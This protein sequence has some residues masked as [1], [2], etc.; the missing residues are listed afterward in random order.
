MDYFNVGFIQPS[1]SSQIESYYCGCTMT[2]PIEDYESHQDVCALR[3]VECHHCNK[4]IKF[5]NIQNHF[6]FL[7]LKIIRKCHHNECDFSGN[8]VMMFEHLKECL[9][10]ITS[11]AIDMN[12]YDWLDCD[13]DTIKVFGRTL[14]NK[15][16][17][18]NI[19]NYSKQASFNKDYS[20]KLI[21]IWLKFN[22][23]EENN[24]ETTCDFNY[25]V[26][27]SDIIL[28]HKK[29]SAP[30]YICYFELECIS[31]HDGY[32]QSYIKTDDIIMI[33]MAF[34]NKKKILI[35]LGDCDPID[36]TE[37]IIASTNKDLF[38]KFQ[39]IIVRE[40]PDIIIGYNIFTFDIPYLMNRAKYLYVP[41]EFYK[42][43]KLSSKKCN[44]SPLYNIDMPGRVQIDLLSLI[45][46]DYKLD[47][48]RFDF[49]LDNFLEPNFLEKYY[50][51]KFKDIVE[52]YN[53][54][55]AGRKI[56]AENCI[57]TCTLVGML[58]NKL[59]IINVDYI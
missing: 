30:F 3:L 10:E 54:R 43:S 1:E 5:C 35:C 40:D 50:N 52:L 25:T 26:E 49:V 47:S 12:V 32:P 48:Y 19:L 53:R 42:L 8:S 51:L 21:T 15:S 37:L 44:W 58:C 46:R 9:Y 20:K 6:D 59:D 16:I 2:F 27:W 11:F 18:V 28:Y 14:D 22:K 41:D 45:Q 57:Q 29:E 13:D 55:S 17:Y 31:G 34:S 7:C 39:A 56:I 24:H 36:D 23:Y 33:G 38:L 4:Q